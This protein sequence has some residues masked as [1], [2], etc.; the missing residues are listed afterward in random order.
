M[1]VPRC[2]SIQFWWIISIRI[3]YFL[4]RAIG[5]CYKVAVEDMQLNL[6][7]L[8]A[9][10][11]LFKYL[12]SWRRTC[13]IKRHEH[14]NFNRRYNKMRYSKDQF[15]N[16]G[17]LVTGYDYNLQVWVIDYIIQ[18]CGHPAS[19]RPGCCNHDRLQGKD[20]RTQ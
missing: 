5:Y 20:I 18:N 11:V 15:D 6:L 17:I 9:I 1:G 8:Q 3:G 14:K 12:A 7:T 16:K 19:M 2:R 4:S 13:S 10:A